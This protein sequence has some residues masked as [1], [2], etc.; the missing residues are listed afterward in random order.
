MEDE[1]VNELNEFSS[2]VMRS[3]TGYVNLYLL[4]IFNSSYTR[5]VL[6]FKRAKFVDGNLF[7]LAHLPF[8]HFQTNGRTTI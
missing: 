5:L 7:Y 2:P 1:P 3:Q 8:L 6:L 4:S